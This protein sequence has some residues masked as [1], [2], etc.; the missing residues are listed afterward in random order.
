MGALMV[1]CPATGRGVSLGVDLDADTFD[2]TPDFAAT[3]HCAACAA[4]HPW[5][6][7]DAWIAAAEFTSTRTKPPPGASP[8]S[9][10]VAPR[11]APVAAARAGAVGNAARRLTHRDGGPPQP[12]RKPRRRSIC[13]RPSWERASRRGNEE[14]G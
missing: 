13:P 7:A 3:F 8:P 6:K 11:R 9:R 12:R 14:E 10:S 5:S 2:R 4:D 1:C